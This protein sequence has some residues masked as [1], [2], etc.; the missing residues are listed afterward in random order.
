[1]RA[2]SQKVNYPPR[3]SLSAYPVRFIIPPMK[4]SKALK[5]CYDL[6]D[7]IFAA[8][9]NAECSR[10]DLARLSCAWERL[11]ERKRVLRGRPLPGTL[12]PEKR[13]PKRT[14]FGDG[15]PSFFEEP[16]EAIE[17]EGDGSQP[18]PGE[19]EFKWRDIPG[20]PGAKEM[21]KAGDNNLP[22]NDSLNNTKKTQ[23]QKSPSPMD[24]HTRPIRPGDR[25]AYTTPP[26]GPRVNATVTKVPQWQGDFAEV[27]IENGDILTINPQIVKWE[28]C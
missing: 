27:R 17:S 13:K 11:E 23:T 2:I 19:P 12:K 25:I 14:P 18:Q 7:L 20:H 26:N 16:T 10:V 1:M 4:I 22:Q 15:M 8:A 3:S 5:Q 6:Q 28:H 9:N 24:A 21:V